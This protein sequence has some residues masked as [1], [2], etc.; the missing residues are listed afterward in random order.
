MGCDKNYLPGLGTFRCL[1]AK[2][3]RKYAQKGAKNENKT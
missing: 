2:T 3:R 1:L